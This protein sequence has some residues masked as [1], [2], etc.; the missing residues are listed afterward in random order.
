MSNAGWYPDPGGQPGMFRYWSGS[1]WSEAITPSP[2]ADGAPPGAPAF[3]PRQPLHP[4]IAGTARSATSGQSGIR[5]SK[6]SPGKVFGLF[7]I[8][9]AVVV[10][11][12]FGI[13]QIPQWTGRDSGNQ[14]SSNPTEIACPTQSAN[15][16]TASATPHPGDGR[17]HGGKLSYPALEAPWSLPESDS[18]VPFGRDVAS[19]VVTVED[20]YDGK[21]NTWVASVLVAELVAGD[22]FFSPEEGADII[23]KCVTGIFYGDAV[24]ERE[25]IASRATTLDGKQAWFLEMHLSFN[26]PGLETKGETALIMVVSTSLESSSLFYASIPDTVP[27]YLPVAR[28]TMANLRVSA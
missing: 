4:G 28:K 25:D 18:R 10:A 9:A 5:T 1:A 12:G 26:I 7:A 14:G 8:V 2:P 16:P 27:E 6:T 19:Q 3:D 20:D 15:V 13:R 21:G 24:V 22:G 23:A 17:V 11:I